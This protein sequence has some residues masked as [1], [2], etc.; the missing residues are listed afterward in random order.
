MEIN[1]ELEGECGYAGWL[2][3]ENDQDYHSEFV[4]CSHG[5]LVAQHKDV[6][7]CPECKG[8]GIGLTKFGREIIDLVKK[9]RHLT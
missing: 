5:K 3:D 9:Y 6:G 8:T 1:L 4:I 7:V 2:T